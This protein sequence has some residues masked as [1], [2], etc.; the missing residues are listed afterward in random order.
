MQAVRYYFMFAGF[1]NPSGDINSF[2]AELQKRFGSTFEFDGRI[3]PINII[4]QQEYTTQ[5]GMKIL[6][7]VFGKRGATSFCRNSNL[8]CANEEIQGSRKLCRIEYG[9]Q[10]ACARMRPKLIIIICN[11][12]VWSRLF[13]HLGRGVAMIK[14]ASDAL[15]SVTK[16]ARKIEEAVPTLDQLFDRINNLPQ[17]EL[18]A[19]MPYYNFQ[20][21]SGNPIAMDVQSDLSKFEQT[22][23]HYHSK[24]HDGG[25]QNPVKKYMRGGYRLDDRIAFQRD[26]LHSNATIG[27]SSRDHIFHLINAY[28][29]YGVAVDPG[30]HFDVVAADGKQVG[31]KFRD[32]VTKKPSSSTSTHLNITPCDRI[33]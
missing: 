26:R 29:L 14:Y 19:R 28:H 20:Q 16:M 30:Y 21:I 4:K 9:G 31:S 7:R 13:D 32:V 2:L 1:T 24:L 11:D 6:E 8:P 27:T 18:A 17:N 33:I 10:T 23:K 5:I 12:I 22:M 15:P 25:F 3:L